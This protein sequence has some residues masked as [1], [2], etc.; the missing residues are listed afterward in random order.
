MQGVFVG[1]QRPKTKKA[2]REAVH[3]DPARVLVEAT[4]IFGNDYGGPVLEMPEVK[5]I[6]ICG[7]DPFTTRNWYATLVRHGNTVTVR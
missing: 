4:S 3:K 1:G 6:Y 7:P 2:L 5:K